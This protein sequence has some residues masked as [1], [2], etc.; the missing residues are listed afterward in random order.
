M[1]F[2][3]DLSRIFTEEE[4]NILVLGV[5]LGKHGKESLKRLRNISNYVE[6]F[7]IDKKRNLFHNI[8]IKDIGDV[9]LE[10]LS[11]RIAE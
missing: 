9:K 1:K 5:P 2:T 8:R 7:D 6:P 3:D 4:S 11:K 10:N